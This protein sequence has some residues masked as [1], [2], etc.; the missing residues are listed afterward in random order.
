MW[1][2]KKQETKNPKQ[3]TPQPNTT[4]INSFWVCLLQ[5]PKAAAEANPVSE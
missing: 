5:T 2:D 4:K 1:L 3:K